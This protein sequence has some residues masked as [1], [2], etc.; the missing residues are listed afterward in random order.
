MVAVQ[1]C[2]HVESQ[3]GR[4]S[5]GRILQ[6]VWT[7]LT[8]QRGYYRSLHELSRFD[9]RLLRDIGLEPGRTQPTICEHSRART[10][11]A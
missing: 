6:A 3:S 4:H 1:H 2:G 7:L 11:L 5:V 10:T 8:Q 9:A